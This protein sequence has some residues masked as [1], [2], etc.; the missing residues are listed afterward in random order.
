VGDFFVTGNSCG[1]VRLLKDEK[2]KS[3]KKADLSKP[4]KVSGFSIVPKAG[5]KFFVVKNEKVAKE[6]I[7]KINY[8]KRIVETQGRRRPITLQMD[9][10]ML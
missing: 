5:D 10:W 8:D 1:K 3:I 2:G 7:N 9:P 4:V 6:L